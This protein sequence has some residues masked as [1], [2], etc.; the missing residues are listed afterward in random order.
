MGPLLSGPIIVDI[1][2]DNKKEIVQ[3]AGNQ[4]FIIRYDGTSQSGWPKGITFNTQQNASIGDI[5]GD[6]SPDIVARD[7][8][9]FTIIVKFMPGTT[10]D[11]YIVDF[12][13]IR[14]WSAI[15]PK[16]QS[17]LISIMIGN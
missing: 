3:S 9:I 17:Y 10:R 15:N 2:G 8:I 11:A 4:V 13:K 5:N 6:E 14:P 7:R 16:R 1:D 12:Q